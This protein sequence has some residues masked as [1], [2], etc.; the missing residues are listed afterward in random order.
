MPSD[1]HLFE[2]LN[3]NPTGKRFAADVEVKQVV[4]SWLQ[5]L[6]TD[7]FY[8]DVQALVPLWDKCLNVNG[9]YLEV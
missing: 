4:T 5:A 3:R 7:F 8:A 2:P 9:D 1:F 6:D